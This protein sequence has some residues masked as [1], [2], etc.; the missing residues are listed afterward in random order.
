MKKSFILFVLVSL[1]ILSIAALLPGQTK[2]GG[3]LCS[4]R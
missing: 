4:I 3:D 1:A 2:G